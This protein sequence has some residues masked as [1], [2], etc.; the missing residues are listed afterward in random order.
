MLWLLTDATVLGRNFI[1][2]NSISHELQESL[3]SQE[4]C[5]IQK[6]RNEFNFT[7]KT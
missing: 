7:R 2:M 3:I 5:R 4:K 6:T 1:R